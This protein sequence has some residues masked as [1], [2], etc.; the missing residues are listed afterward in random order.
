[1]EAKLSTAKI[2]SLEPADKQYFVWDVKFTGLGVRVSPKGGIAFVYQGRVGGVGNAKRITIGKHPL[3]SLKE[4][5]EKAGEYSKLMVQ[6]IDPIRQKKENLE[7]NKTHLKKNI[8]NGIIFG[9][10]FTDYFNV[11]KQD[12]SGRYIQDHIDAAKPNLSDKK[13]KAGCLDYIWLTPL[14]DLTPEYIEDWIRHENKTRK[15]R[16]SQAYRMYKA[17]T[18]WADERERYKGLIP[19]KS[20]TAKIVTTSVQKSKPHKHTLQ[21]QQLENWF[22]V[23]GSINEVQASALTCMLLNG[24]RPNEML[25]LKWENVDFEWKTITIIDK[26][27]QWERIIP[28]TPYTE[29]LISNLPKINDYIFASKRGRKTHIQLAS[30]YRDVIRKSGLPSLPPKAMR[31]SF[32]NLSEWLDVPHGIVKQ[33]MGHRPNAT[34]EKHYKDRAIDLLRHWHIKIEQ[35]ILLEA[36]VDISSIYPDLKREDVYRY[37]ISDA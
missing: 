25:T 36:G 21:R 28:L 34:D 9:D 3:M 37:V 14:V 32:S 12:W 20:A 10:A 24:S 19:E 15:S 33:I 18:N 2:N 13:Y 31:K 16:M 22:K 11:K 30:T 1:M 6:G 8:R 4:A 26:V 23:I 27:D 17:F 29:F 35:F 7:K 5:I